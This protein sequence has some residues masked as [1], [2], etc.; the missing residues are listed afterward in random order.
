MDTR[1]YEPHIPPP[2]VQP[3]ASRPLSGF[4]TVMDDPE[5]RALVF[6]TDY[7]MQPERHRF[8]A[9]HMARALPVH[10]GLTFEDG[11][12]A[13]A[14]AK[15]AKLIM[16]PSHTPPACAEFD[17]SSLSTI[18]E[19]LSFFPRGIRHITTRLAAFE[20]SS[21]SVV[22]RFADL[23]RPGM[24]ELVLAKHDPALP[25]WLKTDLG[26]LGAACAVWLPAETCTRV[27]FEDTRD[28]PEHA[29]VWRP[30]PSMT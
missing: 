3:S 8:T 20:T 2:Y 28:H 26:P 29:I 5:S 14:N 23:C 25:A 15:G 12:V 21:P 11:S 13:F 27:L 4:I 6:G 19:T 16:T 30:S 17:G 18:V 10:V 7:Y 22:A 24:R 9:I 1:L